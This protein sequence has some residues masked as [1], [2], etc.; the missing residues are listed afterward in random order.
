M[1][2]DSSLWN[3]G[4]QTEC[5][6]AEA[7]RARLL[8]VGDNLL[9][10]AVAA[11]ALKE[12]GFTVL[13][14]ASAEKAIDVPFTNI[15]LGECDG[16]EIPHQNLKA[17]PALAVIL[18]SGRSRNCHADSLPPGEAFLAKAYRLPHEINKISRVVH[19]ISPH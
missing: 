5:L 13:S 15:G 3:R 10:A 4:P 18:T 7:S 16:C 17:Q 1:T 11:E 8:V 2:P 14:A 6:L 9:V 19:A 12:A